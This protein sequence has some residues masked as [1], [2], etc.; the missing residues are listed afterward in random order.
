MRNRTELFK[1]KYT[2]PISHTTT[3]ESSPLKHRDSTFYRSSGNLRPLAVQPPPP[4][5]H[6]SQC[7]LLDRKLATQPPL[8]SMPSRMMNIRKKVETNREVSIKGSLESIKDSTN[9][10]VAELRWGVS[11]HEWPEESPQE[12]INGLAKNELFFCCSCFQYVF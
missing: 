6:R 10:S 7:S 1:K 4:N 12:F 9:S 8:S 3:R 5:F 2:E 11:K